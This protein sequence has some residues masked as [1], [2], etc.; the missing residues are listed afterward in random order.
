MTKTLYILLALFIFS[1]CRKAEDIEP[2]FYNCYNNFADGNVTSPN[3]QKFQSLLDEITSNG[4]VGIIMSVHQP[5][6]GM[7]VGASGKADL[8]NNIDMKPCNITRVGSTVKMFTATTVMMLAEEGKL[9][10]DDKISNYLHGDVINKIENAKDATI[11]QLLRHSSGIFNYIQNLKFQTASINDL[12]R[13]WK[14]DELLKYAFNQK[15][16]FQPGD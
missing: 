3:N 4:V 15:A 16:Y 14:P 13:D 1:S 6:S 10:L 11:R 2:N 7:W 12:I 8:H 5:H 9:N